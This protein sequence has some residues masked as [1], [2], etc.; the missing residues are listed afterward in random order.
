VSEFPDPSQVRRHS[1][2]LICSGDELELF[3]TAVD[4]VRE[5][6][7]ETWRIVRCRRCGFGWTEPLLSGDE[8]GRYYPG[9]YLGEIER[10]IDEFLTGS[11]QRSRLWKGE[12]EKVRLVERY[13]PGGRILDVGCGDG[14]FLWALAPERWERFGVERSTEAVTSVR[15]RIP[16]LELFPGDIHS[17]ELI[18]GAF[19]AL[20][21][22]HVLEHLPDPEATLARAAALLCPGG[23]LFVSL[24]C[25]D[26]LQ[27]G[28]FRGLW[29]GFDDVPRHL[30]HFSGRSLNLLLARTG[31]TVHRQLMFSRNVNFHSLKHSLLNW[32]AERHWSKAPYYALKPALFAF[33]LLERMTGR[34]GIRGVV[35]RKLHRGGA[36]VAEKSIYQSDN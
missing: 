20:T 1:R 21:F 13:V 5:R 22:W 27:A 17:G 8:L 30:H 23:W 19:D 35:A 14:K 4:R 33:Q 26:S 31:F 3:C 32:C 25:L 34:S 12:V 6:P 16:G 29:Y 7:G 15:Q 9:H 11:L 18:P 24:P 10:R 36:E 28:L 2:C